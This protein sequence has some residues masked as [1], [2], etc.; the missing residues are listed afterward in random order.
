ML[1]AGHM[2]TRRLEAFSDGVFA[3]AITLLIFNIQPP[4][5]GAEGLWRALRDEWPSYASYAVSFLIIGIIWVNHHGIFDRIVRVDRPLLFLNLLLLMVV[6][7]IPFPTALLAKYIQ[8]GANSHV[9]AAVYR[10]TMTCMAIGFCLIWGYAILHPDLIDERV[11]LAAARATYP[12]FAAGVLIYLVTIAVAFI[13]AIACFILHAVIALYY[14]FDQIANRDALT[15][16][17]ATIQE[18]PES[19]VRTG[20]G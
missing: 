17:T 8:S 12:R 1:Y 13:S 3:V 9:A 11:D 15:E 6:V 18:E 14:V 7:A 16:G 5:A 20:G 19:P 2:T 4:A 10:G